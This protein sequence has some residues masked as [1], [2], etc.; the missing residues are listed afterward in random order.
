MFWFSLIPIIYTL[1]IIGLLY[2]FFKIID[3]IRKSNYER[4]DILRGI[5]EELKKQNDKAEQ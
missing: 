4:N 1:L 3:S 5:Y 2:L